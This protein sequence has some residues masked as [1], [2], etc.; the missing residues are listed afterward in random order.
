MAAV[1]SAAL[2]N[3]APVEE[4]TPLTGYS[5]GN[6]LSKI[7][8]LE[9]LNL[10]GDQPEPVQ[11]LYTLIDAVL[12]ASRNATYADVG[13]DEAV[14]KFCEDH[15]VVHLGGPTLGCIT[16]TSAKVASLTTSTLVF[17]S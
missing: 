15:N 3:A 9:L 17:G 16:D 14:Q 2:V 6:K 7:D 8:G 4:A 11:K 1:S 12:S 10:W 5:P 13:R